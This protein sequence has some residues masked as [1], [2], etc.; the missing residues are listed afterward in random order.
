M[1]NYLP[2]LNVTLNDLG[3]K[4]APPPA[5]PKVTLLGITSNTGIPVREPYTVFSVEKA[6]NS[7]YFSGVTGVNSA[8]TFPGE[9]ALAVEE[10]SNAGAENIEIMIIGHYD[11]TG[12]AGYL[13]IHNDTSITQ[14]YSDLS[15]AYSVLRNR[16]VDVVVPVGVYMDRQ[17]S[18]GDSFGKQLGDFCF[19]ASKEGNAAIGVIP[20]MPI[21]KWACYNVT[22]LKEDSTLSGELSSA[23]GSYWLTTG[24]FTE[25][26]VAN[27]VSALKANYFS[28]P[29]ANL[30]DEYVRYHTKGHGSTFVSDVGNE[31]FYPTTYNA[32]LSGAADQAGNILDDISVSSATSVNAAY[33]AG[34]QAKTTAGTNATDSRGIKVDAGAYI[35]VITAP[36]VA[37]TSQTST[38]ALAYGASPSTLYHTTD[39]A[40]SYAGL[41]LT[42]APQSSTTNKQI[43]GINALKT[44]SATQANYLTG[45]RHVTLYSRSR[46][47]TVASGITGAYRVSKYVTSDYTRLSTVRITT[48]V[49]DIIKAIGEKYIGEPNNAAQINALDSEI[50][51]ALLSLKG[52]GA[53][54]AYQFNIQS[55][56]D[57]RVLGE[58]DINL[59]LVPAFEITQINLTISLASEL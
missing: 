35:S 26:S 56:P 54:N 32:W 16:D 8:G 23:L 42:L 6:I 39:G 4:V 47:L 3:L 51:Q 36:L 9:L 31:V 55:T 19:Q 37:I 40:V 12:L 5:G 11:G 34:W 52:A 18:G 30:T 14:R 1:T 29:S 49:V 50:D 38:L 53:L 57:Q 2:G 22:G 58:L 59:T 41:I 20:T 27:R 21:F 44:L 17:T 7:L 33:F 10:A 24:T 15:G 13:D 45:M 48:T 46:G 25:A 43:P 28:T